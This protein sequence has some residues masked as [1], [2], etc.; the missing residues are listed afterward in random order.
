LSI[1]AICDFK[2]PPKMTAENQ[3]IKFS[4]DNYEKFLLK[5]IPPARSL[6]EHGMAVHCPFIMW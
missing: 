3:R 5:L 2:V 6:I 4:N 1:Y